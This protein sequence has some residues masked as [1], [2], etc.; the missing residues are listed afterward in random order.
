VTGP[1]C[2]I[3]TLVLLG[4]QS[5]SILSGIFYMLL[6]MFI[7]TLYGHKKGIVPETTDHENEE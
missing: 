6:Y 4:F 5:K 7:T 2:I 3:K 1:Y